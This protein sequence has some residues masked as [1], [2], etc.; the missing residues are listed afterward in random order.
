[1]AVSAS[2]REFVL[3]QLGAVA[4]VSA[5]SMFGGVGIYSEGFFFALLDDD[6]LYFKVD[7]S[8]QGD[9]E[10]RGMQAFHPYGDE[11]AMGYF[12]V[13]AEVIEDTDV[14]EAWM[15]KALRVAA[16]R[17]RQRPRRKA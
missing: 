8:N 9:F 16:A 15:R 1:M 13:P 6:T 11:R 3:E 5:K 14:L 2:Y 4:P 10:A 12:E 17:G 7:E